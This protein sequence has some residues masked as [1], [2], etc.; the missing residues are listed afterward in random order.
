MRK[1]A[2]RFGSIDAAEGGTLAVQYEALS[3]V[4]ALLQEF[5]S[6]ERADAEAEGLSFAAYEQ[7]LAA[8]NGIASGAAD[9]MAKAESAAAKFVAAA[10]ALSML[11]AAAAVLRF[12]R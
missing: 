8:Y 1:C 10:A 4:Q 6:E 2:R 12:G 5:G 7:M 11:A 9:D 3:Q